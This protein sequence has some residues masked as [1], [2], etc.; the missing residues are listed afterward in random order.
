MDAKNLMKRLDQ[1]AAEAGRDYSADNPSADME[2]VA[3]DL[4]AGAKYSFEPDEWDE[5]L[6][7]FDINMDHDDSRT[8]EDALIDYIADTVASQVSEGKIRVKKS[9]LRKF[10]RESLAQNSSDKDIAAAVLPLAQ[11]QDWPKAA[12][13]LLSI[14]S[15]ADL[16]NLLDDSTLSDALENVG[17]SYDDKREIE[18]AAW[19]LEDARM[20]AAIAADP[21]KAWLKFLGNEWTS[22]IEP[23]DMKGIKWKEYKRYVRLKPPYSIS[24]GVGEIN[25]TRDNVEGYSN[26]PG[27]Y[28]EFIEFLGRRAGDQLGKRKPY[29]RSP[30]PYYD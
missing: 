5:L 4:A 21:D 14:F 11:A 28:E 18:T 6:T 29:R 24:H 16:Q 23:D 20:Q 3:R 13:L 15:Y 19:P 12:E 8:A 2:G 27:T 10:I 30:A 9:D 25:V 17:V 7:H 26:S 22:Q 1:W